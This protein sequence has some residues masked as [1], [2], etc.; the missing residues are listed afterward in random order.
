MTNSSWL[1]FSKRCPARLAL[2]TSRR[3][4]SARAA[5]RPWTAQIRPASASFFEAGQVRNPC[6][7]AADVHRRQFQR[8][9]R[10]GGARE[11]GVQP[12]RARNALHQQGEELHMG[13]SAEGVD[14]HHPRAAAEYRLLFA[15]GGRL[16][17]Q[18]RQAQV[19]PGHLAQVPLRQ[20]GGDLRVAI[21]DQ[22]GHG[23][24][25]QQQGAVAQRQEQP[26]EAVRGRVGWGVPA[27]AILLDHGLVHVSTP[28]GAQRAAR[29]LTNAS[30][31]SR[32]LA[33]KLL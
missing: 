17:G 1:C 32:G 19:A 11:I 29:C 13:S 8:R 5:G 26:S 10:R 14:D 9:Q 18:Q 22:F 23:D 12:H 6:G 7:F 3:R 4:R 16:E 24:V 15:A 28:V 21:G 30:A 20:A 2:A 31:S 33:L 27:H 25:G